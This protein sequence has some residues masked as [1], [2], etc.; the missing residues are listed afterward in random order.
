MHARM[1]AHV[2][3]HVCAHARACV[4]ACVRACARMCARMRA[5]ICARI[6][7]QLCAQLC[8]HMCWGSAC[9]CARTCMLRRG[10]MARTAFHDARMFVCMGASMRAPCRALESE[11]KRHEATLL[12]KGLFQEGH[13]RQSDLILLDQCRDLD[14]SRPWISL[15]TSMLIPT[16][17]PKFLARGQNMS[18]LRPN[19]KQMLDSEI[20]ADEA[21]TKSSQATSKKDRRAAKP[22]PRPSYVHTQSISGSLARCFVHC[23]THV[24]PWCSRIPLIGQRQYNSTACHREQKPPSSTKA[25]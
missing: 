10:L 12:R 25:H 22:L 17:M 8:A 6:C 23:P 3:A 24:P 5:R 18:D 11:M 15:T 13:G 1:R 16:S 19:S 21:R 14:T 9:K 20:L 2:C 4:R 7:A